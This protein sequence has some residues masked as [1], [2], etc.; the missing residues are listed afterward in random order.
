[1]SLGELS[2]YERLVDRFSQS[3]EVKGSVFERAQNLV[4]RFR[5]PFILSEAAH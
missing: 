1:M 3:E 2:D 5:K 4:D